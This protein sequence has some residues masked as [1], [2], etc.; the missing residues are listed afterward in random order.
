[1]IAAL[2]SFDEKIVLLAGGRDK[3]LPWD[4]AARLIVHKTSQVILF[5]EAAELI[6]SAIAK[7]RL[8]VTVTDTS[9]QLCDN[10]EQA[11]N[12][13]PQV[14]EAGGVILLSPGCASFDAFRD[15]AERGERFMELVSAL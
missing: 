9:V 1:M 3:H 10:L 14:A 15:F 13:A 2:R 6:S 8:E 5:G 12:L 7:A 4:D 11:I